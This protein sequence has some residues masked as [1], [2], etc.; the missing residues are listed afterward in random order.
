MAVRPRDL[1]IACM[2][3]VGFASK[4]IF[5]K[6]L[7]ARGWDYESVLAVRAIV[8]LPLVCA[9]VIWRTGLASVLRIPRSALIGVWA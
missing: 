1:L 7:Y 5:A 9:V 2:A 6:L 8:A 4:G 3:S